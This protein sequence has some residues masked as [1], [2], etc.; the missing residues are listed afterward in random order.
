MTYT[1]DLMERWMPRYLF[2]RAEKINREV[3]KDKVIFKLME[4]R[5]IS[6]PTDAL[7]LLCLSS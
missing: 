7:K 6:K 1:Y 5:V 3:A 4:N 2:E